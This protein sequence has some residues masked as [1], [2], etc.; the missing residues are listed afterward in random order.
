[1]SWHSSVLSALPSSGGATLERSSVTQLAATGG[2][3]AGS[4]GGVAGRQLADNTASLDDRQRVVS[5]GK[6][7]LVPAKAGRGTRRVMLASHGRLQWYYPDTDTTQL[8]HEGGVRPH[9][10]A[11]TRLKPAPLHDPMLACHLS[12]CLRACRP[13]ADLL[14]DMRGLN[15]GRAL[16]HFPGYNRPVREAAERMGHV[17]AAQLA[18]EKHRGSAVAPGCGNGCVCLSI[19]SCAYL[20]FVGPTLLAEVAAPLARAC[21]SRHMV[22]RTQLD[23]R[24]IDSRFTH[25]VVSAAWNGPS[26]HFA[27]SSPRVL[28]AMGGK[29]GLVLHAICFRLSWASVN[30]CTQLRYRENARARKHDSARAR[31][32][33]VRSGNSVFLCDTEGGKVLELAYPSMKLVAEMALFTRKH[34][35]NTLAPLEPGKVWAVLNNLGDVSG[36][37]VV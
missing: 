32:E 37:L 14:V 29:V 21:S 23:R 26:G 7:T 35:V 13:A 31:L 17:A 34:H 22:T 27:C 10:R 5:D 19:D 25:D 12:A 9:A 33:Q 18:A 28:S 3:S 15:A 20:A 36:A 8:L 24:V 11:C 4:I 1:M 6:A 16:W 2:G 30:A